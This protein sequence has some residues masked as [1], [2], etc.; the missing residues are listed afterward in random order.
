MRAAVLAS[1]KHIVVTERR[2]PEAGPRQVLV[3]VE[4]CGICGSDVHG[5]LGEITV[6]PG[7]VMGHECSGTVAA[8]RKDVAGK[9]WLRGRRRL[10]RDERNEEET[11]QYGE[12]YQRHHQPFRHRGE[13]VQKAPFLPG[14]GEDSRSSVDGASHA[15]APGAVDISSA[16]RSPSLRVP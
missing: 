15:A 16:R 2:T 10:R 1:V 4:Y 12:T 11:N 3:K 9:P 5:Y 13:R 6:L 7:T 8:I 14:D